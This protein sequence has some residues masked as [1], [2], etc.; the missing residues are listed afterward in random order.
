MKVGVV[1]L[2]NFF[3]NFITEDAHYDNTVE[4]LNYACDIAGK[5]DITIAN[6]CV[7]NRR[8]HSRIL[9]KVNKTN[10]GVFFDSMNYKFFSKY[11]QLE[12]LNDVYPKMI[13]Q[14]HVKDG[15]DG[16]SGSRL[17]QGNMDFFKQIELLKEKKYTGWII[18]E[19]YYCQLPLR[20]E[21]EKDQLQLLIEDI[22]TLKDALGVE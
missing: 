15:V 3:D 2:P 13:P 16:L 14:L 11:D 21:N 9:D 1:M 22:K 4:A 18:I 19:N 5:Y 8:D 12:I 6:E 20:A 10:I 7:L 17:G